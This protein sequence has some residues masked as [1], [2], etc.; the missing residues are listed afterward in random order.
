MQIS[1]DG[2]ATRDEKVFSFARERN[3]PI[4]MLTS[5]TQSLLLVYNT[6]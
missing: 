1:P 5:G 2:I 3:I 6:L 4:I